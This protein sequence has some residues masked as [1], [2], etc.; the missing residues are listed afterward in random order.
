LSPAQILNHFQGWISLAQR[1]VES[2][3]R[4]RHQKRLEQSLDDLEVLLSEQEKVI[5]LLKSAHGN[6]SARLRTGQS[7]RIRAVSDAGSWNT[8]IATVGLFYGP[9]NTEISIIT[10]RQRRSRDNCQVPIATI[11]R[12]VFYISSEDA[13]RYQASAG[14]A[15]PL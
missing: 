10:E 4:S 14:D 8:T 6:V 2:N 11:G 15:A 13:K 12:L 1:S 7:T 5:E 3:R 9:I